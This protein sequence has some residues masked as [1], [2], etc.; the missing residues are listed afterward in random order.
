MD[1][2]AKAVEEA[3]VNYKVAINRYAAENALADGHLW[4]LMCSGR[5]WR[6]RR[7]GATQ[8]WK[9][10][11][12]R[13][14]IPVKCGL[15]SCARITETSVIGVGN[16]QDKPDFLVSSNDPNIKEKLT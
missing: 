3:R 9:R 15:K 1:K 2:L 7:N 12:Q 8:T 4:A 5:W 6:L 14:S 11:P 10:D 16:P 13:F